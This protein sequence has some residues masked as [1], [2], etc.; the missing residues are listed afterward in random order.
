[1][2]K[3][4]LFYVALLMATTPVIAANPHILVNLT[5]G[6]ILS[7][8]RADDRWYPASLTKLMTAYV[9]FRAISKGEL[10]EGSPVIIS[11]LASQ[12]P[13]GKMG[14]KA[15]TTIRVDTALKITV[16]KSAN[17]VSVAL[18]EAVAGSMKGFVARMNSEARRLGLINTHF[19]NANGL[20]S[21]NQYS[22]ARD[23]TYLSAQ[24]LREFPQYA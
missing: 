22:S 19:V 24:I 3:T 2:L 8:S 10:E 17:D 20:H 21:K 18:A 15:G 5:S 6:K 11:K 9:T 1:L 16:V 4:V 14:Y 13:P 12:Q 23:M 7:Q